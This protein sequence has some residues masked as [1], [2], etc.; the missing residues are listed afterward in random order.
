MKNRIKPTSPGFFSIMLF[1]LLSAISASAATISWGF[2]NTITGDAGTGIVVRNVRAA[3]NDNVQTTTTGT[4]DIYTAGTSVFAIN[5]TGVAFDTW[6]NDVTFFPSAPQATTFRSAESVSA[7]TQNAVTLSLNGSWSGNTRFADGSPQ[8]NAYGGLGGFT[9]DTLSY[10]RFINATSGSLTFSGLTVGQEYAVQYWVQD[11]RNLADSRTLTLDGQTTLDFNNGSG[12]GQ[13]AIGTFTANSTSQD[14]F[15]AANQ[16]VQLNMLQLRAIP[17][18]S[19]ALLS[20]LGVLGL[21]RRR[22][23]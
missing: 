4:A 3:F 8:G 13:W 18:P 9:W 2:A 11:S 12:V 5:F 14:I 16:S 10:M 15:I 21:L 19:T 6:G 20:G 23:K 17:E 1:G 22:R 7:F